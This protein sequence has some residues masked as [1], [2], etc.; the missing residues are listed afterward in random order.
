MSIVPLAV[1]DTASQKSSAAYMA[2]F[3]DKGNAAFVHDVL[4]NLTHGANLPLIENSTSV[5]K[6][7]TPAF[8]CAT[9][10][11]RVQW[12]DVG[13]LKQDAYADCLAEGAAAHALLG[14]RIIILCPD[15]FTLPAEPI[16]SKSN[17]LKPDAQ[18]IGQFEG[19]GFA[20]TKYQM[21]ILLHELVHAY[22]FVANGGSLDIYWVNECLDLPGNETVMNAQ[23]FTYYVASELATSPYF[24]LPSMLPFWARANGVGRFVL[25]LH[26]F[27][28]S[29]KQYAKWAGEWY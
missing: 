11:G 27:S 9:Q 22:V 1:R 24:L 26:K 19:D 16:R 12:L 13:G 25:G 14:V 15:F 6:P 2:F 8:V 20:F 17:C 29:W 18:Q 5:V 3:K 21:W 28:S 7:G 10:P 23:S 4:Y